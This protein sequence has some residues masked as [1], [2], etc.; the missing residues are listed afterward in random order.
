MIVTLQGLLNSLYKFSPINEI[1]EADKSIASNYELFNGMRALIYNETI[2]NF[3]LGNC[4][5][6][7]SLVL[8]FYYQHNSNQSVEIHTTETHAFVIVENKLIIDPWLCKIYSIEDISIHCKEFIYG[9]KKTELGLM[10][11]YKLGIL[12]R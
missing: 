9:N 11:N 4:Q 5:E 8:D 6:L 2:K 10:A 12:F 7:C 3:K 1:C